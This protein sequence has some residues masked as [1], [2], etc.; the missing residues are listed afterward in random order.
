ML[1][2]EGEPLVL[3]EIEGRALDDKAL[4][5]GPTL[6][7]HKHR[8]QLSGTQTLPHLTM[9]PPELS[10]EATGCPL[11]PAHT[12]TACL[13]PSINFPGWHLILNRHLTGLSSMRT[14]TMLPGL[15][16]APGTQ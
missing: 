3:L 5:H 13:L 9:C 12:Q 15:G 2:K 7:L 16:T 10:S 11:G 8:T 1:P 4:L 14:G 6:S